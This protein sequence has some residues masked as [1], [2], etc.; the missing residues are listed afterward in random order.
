MDITHTVLYCTVWTAYH[1]RRGHV[2]VTYGSG[3]LQKFDSSHMT[4][5]RCVL[6]LVS[7]YDDVLINTLCAINSHRMS[8]NTELKLCV[9]ILSGTCTVDVNKMLTKSFTEHVSISDQ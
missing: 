4:Y 1:A 8:S 9:S 7:L 2:T 3:N 6:Y 5:I